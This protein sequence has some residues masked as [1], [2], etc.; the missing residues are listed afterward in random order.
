MS[1]RKIFKGEK[2]AISGELLKNGEKTTDAA[3]ELRIYRNSVLLD[4]IPFTKDS[5]GKYTAE[6]DTNKI[7]G[8]V[9]ARLVLNLSDDELVVADNDI[10]LFINE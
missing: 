4:T 8:H 5:D 7:T 3:A 1:V 10:E 6:V 2:L 9:Y